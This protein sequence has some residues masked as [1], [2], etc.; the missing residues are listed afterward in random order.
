MGVGG[1]V[2]SGLG[3]GI[4]HEVVELALHDL[5]ELEL[6]HLNAVGCGQSL[7]IVV[8]ETMDVEFT[9]DVRNVVILEVE[10]TLGMLDHD[11]GIGSNEKFN[12][13]GPRT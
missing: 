10:N 5:S 13:L 6:K 2:V 12:W 11:G 7:A 9:I 1:W 3:L 8:V 4:L